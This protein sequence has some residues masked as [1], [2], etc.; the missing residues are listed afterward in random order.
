MKKLGALA[1]AGLLLVGCSGG[2]SKSSSETTSDAKPAVIDAKGEW[3]AT[4]KDPAG[5]KLDAKMTFKDDNSYVFSVKSPKREVY[6]VTGKWSQDAD[7]EVSIKEPKGKEY[8]ESNGG[9]IPTAEYDYTINF[10]ED[11]TYSEGYAGCYVT[12]IDFSMKKK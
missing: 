4:A 1:I 8:D 12:A 7:G 3:V 9:F 11:S 2:E 6:N 5:V 10:G